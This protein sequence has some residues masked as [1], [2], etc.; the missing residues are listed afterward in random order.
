MTDICNELWAQHIQRSMWYGVNINNEGNDNLG[1]F[2]WKLAMVQI[3]VLTAALSL[4]MH[5]DETIKNLCTTM[6]VPLRASP[7]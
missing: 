7:M 3:N 1:A 5:A 6:E 2:I 4:I